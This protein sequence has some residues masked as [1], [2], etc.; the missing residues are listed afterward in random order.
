MKKSEMKASSV[1]KFLTVLL[2]LVI[3]GAIGGFYYGLQQVRSFAIEVNHS[4]A[5]A[6]ASGKQIDELRILKSTLAESES[7]VAKANSLFATNDT[8]QAQA[9]KDIQKYAS[10]YGLT[11]T[12]TDFDPDQPPITT[13]N[14]RAFEITLQSPLSYSNLLKFLDAIEGNLPKMQIV[15][16]NL[17]RPTPPVSNTVASQAIT[18]VIST[19]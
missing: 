14:G 5:D 8:Y 19:R 11:V 12:N 15:S 4:L 17:S 10:L 7:L 6:S 16:I 3:A 2:V 13:V 18:I 9:L 1:R